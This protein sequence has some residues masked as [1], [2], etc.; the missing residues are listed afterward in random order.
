MCLT[1]PITPLSPSPSVEHALVTSATA[2]TPLTPP[3]TR[4][5]R[6]PQTRDRQGS[7]QQRHRHASRQ[8]HRQHTDSRPYRSMKVDAPNPGGKPNPDYKSHERSNY[9]QGSRLGGKESVQQPLRSPQSLHNRK[10]TA[11]VKYP[12][13]QGCEQA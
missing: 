10:I 6:P 11:P 3:K 7:R 13:R 9:S 1:A 2:L 12:P 8:H 4:A 5:R